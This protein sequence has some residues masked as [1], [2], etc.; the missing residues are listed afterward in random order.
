MDTHKL[1]MKILKLLIES[2][3]SINNQI[4]VIKNVKERLDFCKNTAIELKQLKLDL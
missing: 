4:L 3:L 2:E 1:A